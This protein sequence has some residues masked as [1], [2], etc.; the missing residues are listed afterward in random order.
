MRFFYFFQ[1][2][3][4]NQKIN[5]LL[6]R[7]N[8]L[9]AEN[10]HI[11]PL[12]ERCKKG[13]KSAQFKVYEMYYKAMYNSAFRILKNEFD[14]EDIMQE[15][16]LTA[17]TKLDSFRGEVSFGLWLKKIII[18]KSLTQLKNNNRFEE[19]S[20]EFVKDIKSEPD[21]IDYE[22]INVK[23]ILNCINNLKD[24]YRIA[25]TLNLIEGYDYDEISQI[26]GYTNE[27][28]RAIISRGKKKLKELL[29]KNEK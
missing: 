11:N 16:F 22:N 8:F 28:V 18:N 25:L 23:H 1:K 14:A 24:N 7:T 13:D 5:C 9:K 26:L 20:L 17:F 15:G 29:Q 27:N 2:S 10:L 4:T 19:V 21:E 6:S 3:V 12:I